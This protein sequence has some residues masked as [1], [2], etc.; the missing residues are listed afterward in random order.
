[1][2]L[3]NLTE[4][5]INIIVS[6]GVEKVIPPSGVVAR[7]EV[8]KRQLGTIEADGVFVPVSAVTYGEVTGL[9]A[10]AR[11]TVYIVSARVLEATNRLDVFAPDTNPDSVVRDESG[12]VI[13]VR[14]LL[15]K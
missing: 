4:H 2:K 8:K 12:R 7:V 5:P 13:G 10:P 11:D 1:M 15:R 3:I 14:G 9:P 6:D